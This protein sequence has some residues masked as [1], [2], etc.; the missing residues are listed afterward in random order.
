MGSTKGDC[1]FV[2]FHLRDKPS[3]PFAYLLSFVLTSSF[4]IGPVVLV[5]GAQLR[6]QVGGH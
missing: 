3:R 6:Y 4:L 5:V 1:A 2:V